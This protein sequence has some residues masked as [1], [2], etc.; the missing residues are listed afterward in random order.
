MSKVILAEYDAKA[1]V[2]KLPEPLPGVRD[3]ERVPL[4]IPG[5]E[6]AGSTSRKLSPRYAVKLE[7]W[8]IRERMAGRTRKYKD[9]ESLLRRV[10][11]SRKTRT[12]A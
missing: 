5:R 9:V 7:K 2:L 10:R 1:R 3:R 11:R 6:R 12:K 8:A 4:S